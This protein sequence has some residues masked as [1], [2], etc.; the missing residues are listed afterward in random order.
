MIYHIVRR[1]VDAGYQPKCF[2]SV[3]IVMLQKPTKPNYTKLK[4]YDPVQLLECLEK[5][6]KRAVAMCLAHFIGAHHLVSEHQLGSRPVSYAVYRIMSYLHDVDA[7]RKPNLDMSM[8]TFHISGFHNNVSHNQLLQEMRSLRLPLLLV[9]WT[10]SF[11]SDSQGA[12]CLDSV[13]ENIS[14]APIGVPQGSLASPV[15]AIYATEL[16]NKM[17]GMHVPHH[18]LTQTSLHL[19]SS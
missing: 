14:P 3:V 1:C 12:I 15:L 13:H 5:V 4:A 8:L 18:A 9:R 11:C 19:P 10:W 7:A 2:Q 6:I 17:R 16:A